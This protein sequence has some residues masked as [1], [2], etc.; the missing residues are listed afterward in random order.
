L[1]SLLTGALKWGVKNSYTVMRLRVRLKVMYV[2]IKIILRTISR[3]AADA[4]DNMPTFAPS[5]YSFFVSYYAG[6]A[7]VV[8]SVTANDLDTGSWGD[9]TYTLDQVRILHSVHT[10]DQ[11]VLKICLKKLTTRMVWI[12]VLDFSSYLLSKSMF[13]LN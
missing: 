5:Q 4:N 6:A 1:G 7:T 3:F 2:K 9:L 13:R 10:P 11:K 8:G 12:Y